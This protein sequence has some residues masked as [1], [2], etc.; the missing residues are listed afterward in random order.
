L[1][2]GMVAEI[3][4]FPPN[5]NPRCRKSDN[6]RSPCFLWGQSTTGWALE[7]SSPTKTHVARTSARLSLVLLAP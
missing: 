6:F 1:A 3:V 7:H 4:R 5:L 2:L